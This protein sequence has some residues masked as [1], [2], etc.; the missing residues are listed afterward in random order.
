[1]RTLRFGL[2]AWFPALALALPGA[3]IASDSRAVMPLAMPERTYADLADLADAATL[4]IR[5]QPRD[6]IPIAPESAKGVQ[7]GW[8]RVYVRA[9]TEA[10]IGGSTAVGASLSY[11][12][13]VPLNAKG[14]LPPIRKKS[15][16]LFA[17]P[18]AGRPGEVQLVAPDAQIVWDPALEGR[19]KAILT[20]FYAPDAPPRITGVREALYVAGD[21]A[22]AGETQIFLNTAK[23]VPAAITVTRVPG[24]TPAVSVS[25]SEVMSAQAAVPPVDTAA[26]YRLACFL[27]AQLPASANISGSAQDRAAASA[28]YRTAIAGLQACRRNRR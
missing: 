26:W 16:V 23:G 7:A 17:R 1:M 10:L 18:V 3:A 15:M 27:P 9:R 2:F 21:L 11:L 6:V 28:D 22:G 14:K 19:I 5:V 13:D 8:A 24:Q 12:V 20:E 4:V 25:F